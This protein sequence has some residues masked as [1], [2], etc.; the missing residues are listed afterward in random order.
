[1][2]LHRLLFA[3]AAVSLMAGAAAAQAPATAPAAAPAAAPATPGATLSKP[4][5]PQGDTM[6]TLRLNGQFTTLVKALDASNLSSLLQTRPGMTFFAPPDAAFAALPAGDLDKM[7]ADPEKKDLRKLLLHHLVN[8][9]VPTAKIKGTRGPWPTGGGDK[10]VLDGSADAGPVKADNATIIQADVTT[11][12]GTIQVVD[13][14]LIAGSVPE[15][16]PQPEPE[17]AP[18]APPPEPAKPAPKAPAKKK[19]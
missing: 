2:K 14:V 17:A 10:V 19:K 13:H 18:A 8:A 3:A 16:L 15:T 11:S 6:A 9:P 7:L 12:N 4:L 5:A 1:M